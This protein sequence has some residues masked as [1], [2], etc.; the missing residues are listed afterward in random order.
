MMVNEFNCAK[1]NKLI[2][3]ND[4]DYSWY[5]NTGLCKRCAEIEEQTNGGLSESQLEYIN[6]YKED[7]DSKNYYLFMGN[8]I[9]YVLG[10][11]VYLVDGSGKK[12]FNYEAFLV[13]SNNID[14]FRLAIEGRKRW[15][16]K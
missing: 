11:D 6:T 16:K 14:F 8:I 12:L 1:C 9:N 4:T 13:L 10:E 2:L 7:T 15:N 3:V 5:S